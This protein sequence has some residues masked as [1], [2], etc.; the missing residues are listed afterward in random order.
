MDFNAW[1]EAYLGEPSYIFDAG[2]ADL[3]EH[4]RRH[5]TSEYAVDRPR[6]PRRIL[7][8]RRARSSSPALASSGLRYAL[9]RQTNEPVSGRGGQPGG[10]HF[11]IDA[12]TKHRSIVAGRLGFDGDIHG[13]SFGGFRAVETAIGSSKP[14][15]RDNSQWLKR[16]Q[17]AYRDLREHTVGLRRCRSAWSGR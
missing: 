17:P 6:P 13:W 10:D 11:L 12:H 5:P 1:F 9:W 4:S 7:R 8:P 14:C 3:S 2:I 16:N 15:D